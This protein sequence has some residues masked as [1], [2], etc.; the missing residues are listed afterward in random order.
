MLGIIAQTEM[1]ILD[2]LLGEHAAVVTLFEYIE[3]GAARMD[4]DRI[5][6]AGEM[7]ERVL[8]VHSVAEDR[9]LFDAAPA[10]AGGLKDVLVAMRGEHKEMALELTKL[11]ATSSVA[12]GRGSL[13]RLMQMTREHFEVEERVLF[14]V[15]RKQMSAETLEELGERWKRHRMKEAQA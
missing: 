14:P 12:A 15:A 5:H 10:A 11:R 6:E 7:L 9:F 2:A 4:I 3:Q 8:M 1:N 13:L